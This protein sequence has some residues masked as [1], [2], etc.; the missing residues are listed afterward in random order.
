MYTHWVVGKFAYGKLSVN[1]LTT[2][3]IVVI[4]IRPH[5]ISWCNPI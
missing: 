1:P 2:N 3:D 4:E 5:V